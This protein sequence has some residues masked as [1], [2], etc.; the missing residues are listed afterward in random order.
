METPSFVTIENL[1]RTECVTGCVNSNGDAELV[2]LRFH[3]KEGFLDRCGECYQISV[4]ACVM[5]GLLENAEIDPAD[6]CVNDDF[7]RLEL[8]SCELE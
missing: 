7:M 1:T 3:C 2:S 4:M 8:K 5:S 6:L